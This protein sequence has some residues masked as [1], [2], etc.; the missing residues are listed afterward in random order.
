MTPLLQAN[1]V[2]LN[3]FMSSN[4]DLSNVVIVSPDA[5]G[6]ARA[7]KF[8]ELFNKKTKNDCSLAMI[9]K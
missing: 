1:M 8:Q 4:I 2:A 5:G 3:Y 9:I 7:K 6:V